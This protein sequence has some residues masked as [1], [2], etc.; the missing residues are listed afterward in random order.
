MAITTLITAAKKPGSK[1]DVNFVEPGKAKHDVFMNKLHREEPQAV[2]LWLHGLSESDHDHVVDYIDA[3]AKS[4]TADQKAALRAVFKALDVLDALPPTP[5][6]EHSRF[7]TPRVKTPKGEIGPPT[8]P[9]SQ[10]KPTADETREAFMTGRGPL[11]YA[12][13]NK[14]KLVAWRKHDKGVWYLEVQDARTGK[15]LK[16]PLMGESEAGAFYDNIGR[17]PEKPKVVTPETTNPAKGENTH[18][19][20]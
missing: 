5:I 9:K 16:R 12:G 15:V 7:K 14:Q 19:R 4:F 17:T 11:A 1:P 8:P 10:K 18:S 2:A 3:K 20:W 6:D 13:F